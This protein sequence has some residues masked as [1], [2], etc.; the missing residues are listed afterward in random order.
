MCQCPYC[1]LLIG[2]ASKFAEHLEHVHLRTLQI[3]HVAV[4][5]G[6]ITAANAS[7][8]DAVLLSD[9]TVRN[10]SEIMLLPELFHSLA[11]VAPS[12][13]HRTL[14]WTTVTSAEDNY[15][16]TGVPMPDVPPFATV[17]NNSA[18]ASSITESTSRDLQARFAIVTTGSRAVHRSDM[19]TRAREMKYT[20]PVTDTFSG[21]G[22][23]LAR[24][25]K[26]VFLRLSA[27]DLIL[28]CLMDEW[29][30]WL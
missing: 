20:T 17:V 9:M 3:R 21:L 26:Q 5:S 2:S 15:V 23:G 29:Q 24:R 30:V 18:S 4:T 6:F 11:E 27:N 8:I 14:R 7:S 19:P 22:I 1:F 28:C 16:P 12:T 10:Q 25:L 13:N